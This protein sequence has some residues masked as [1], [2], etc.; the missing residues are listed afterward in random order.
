MATEVE[1]TQVLICGCGPIGAMLLGFLGRNN[2][3]NVILEKEN[4]ITIDPRGI[5]L[6]DDGIRLLQAL[7]LYDA[8]FTDIGSYVPGARFISGVHT[9]LHRKPFLYFNTGSIAGNTG[10]VGV[11][12]HK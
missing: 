11:L 12:C 3:S 6:D 10:H 4:D 2:V 9:D 8:V 7:G 5:A 1:T